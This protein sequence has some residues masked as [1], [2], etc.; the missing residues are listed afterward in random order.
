MCGRF[1]LTVSGKVLAEV[2]GT[3]FPEVAP[4]YNIAPTQEV[5][6]VRRESAGGPEAVLLRWGLIPHWAEGPRIGN[7]MINARAETAHLRPAFRDSSVSYTHL[8]LTTNR[9]V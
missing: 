1:T 6:V 9:E 5:L 2:F 7:R 4:R 8:T 3:T